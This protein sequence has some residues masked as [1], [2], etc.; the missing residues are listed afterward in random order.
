M[1]YEAAVQRQILRMYDLFEPHV[2][3]TKL[4]AESRAVI[5]DR[6]RWGEAHGQFSK[7][8]QRLLK[9]EKK[10]KDRRAAFH[11]SFLEESLKT[12]FNETG[13]K[14]PFDSISPFFVVPLALELASEIGLPLSDVRDACRHQ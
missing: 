8:R 9:V 14:M 4:H 1:G 5:S 12:V 10:G 3:D 7:V 11:L 6:E 2:K 13:S